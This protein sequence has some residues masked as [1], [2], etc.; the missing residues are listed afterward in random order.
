M[1]SIA[2]DGREDAGRLGREQAGRADH[3][4]PLV[5]LTGAA[6]RMSDTDRD[7]AAWRRTPSAYLS[8]RP[9]QGPVGRLRS[10]YIPIPD[11]C[12]LAVDVYLPPEP[13]RVPTVLIFTP[14]YRRFALMTGAPA[15]TEACPGI[16]RWRDLFYPRLCW[17]I[18]DEGR[19]RL[20]AEQPSSAT[21]RPSGRPAINGKSAGFGTRKLSIEFCSAI[22]HRET[23][24]R[25][26]RSLRLDPTN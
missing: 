14:Y 23:G 15:G 11:G 17:C 1:A 24:F 25:R 20:Q 7:S 8:T 4:R 12:R 10:L 2:P 26:V 6:I 9:A 3:V 21:S 13:S 16:A 5:S 22:S 18:R 19:A